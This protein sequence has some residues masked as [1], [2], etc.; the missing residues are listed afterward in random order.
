LGRLQ[1]QH[2]EQHGYAAGHDQH[3]DWFGRWHEPVTSG[4]PSPGDSEAGRAVGPAAGQQ[5]EVIL[6][7]KS[8]LTL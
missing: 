4:D 1:Y 7:T 6:Q 5:L 3:H 8:L 2:G